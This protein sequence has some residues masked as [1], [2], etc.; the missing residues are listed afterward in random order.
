MA[1]LTPC[2]PGHL[3]ASAIDRVQRVHRLFL[4]TLEARLPE[5][6]QSQVGAALLDTRQGVM[7]DCLAVAQAGGYLMALDIAP[8]RGYAALGFPAELLR[9]ILDILLAKPAGIAAGQQSPVTEI[10]IHVLRD[11]FEGFT[12]TLRRAW[13][14]V[15]A[16]SFNRQSIG[17]DDAKQILSAAPGEPV[18]VLTSRLK[19]AGMD[20][21]FDLTLPGFL[22]RMAE[23]HAASTQTRDRISRP[24]EAVVAG[25]LGAALVEL[26]AVLQGV[27]LRMGDLLALKPEQVLLLGAPVEARFDCLVNGKAQF[28]GEMLAGANRHCFQVEGINT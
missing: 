16:A 18:L 10:E 17:A 21:T 7:A 11:F 3:P 2:P 22:V 25:P 14:T 26:E 5:L 1:P 20:H 4:K 23:A 19:V 27:T 6:V 9:S 24:D 13:A 8:A 15:F 12:G 28:T